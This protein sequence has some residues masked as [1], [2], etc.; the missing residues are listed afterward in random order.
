M[1]GAG[2]LSLP[3]SL[4]LAGYEVEANEVSHHQL[5]ASLSMLKHAENDPKYILYPWALS[6]SNHVCRVDQFASVL[7]PDIQAKTLLARSRRAGT[8][9]ISMNDFIVE[10]SKPCYKNYF[11]AVTTLF[12]YRH[13]TQPTSLH[14]CSQPRSQSWRNVDQYRA[15]SMELL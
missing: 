9:T 7:I 13:R 8:L 12:F 4:Q 3:L 5:L 11:D 15:T 14:L 1:A 6:F 10:Y 2:L